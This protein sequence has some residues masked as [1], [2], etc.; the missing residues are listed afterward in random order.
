MKIRHGELKD[1][2]EEKYALYN[3]H[4]FIELDP[5]SIPAR[6][7]K[8]GDIEI[9]G[10]MAAAIAWGQRPV[11]IKNAASLLHAMDDAPHDFI[12]NFSKSDLAPFRKFVHRT[13]NGTDCVFFLKSLQQIY[14]QH[15]SL[16]NLFRKVVDKNSGSYKEAIIGVRKEFFKLTHEP[17]TQ[18]HFADPGKGSAAKR[19]NM[20]LR[21]MIRKDNLGVDFGIWK[22]SPALLTCPL[23]VH[24][25]RVARQLGLLKRK[26]NDW[27][28]AEELTNNLRLFDPSDPVK[29]DF[30]LFGL[31]V[32]NS[33]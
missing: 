17:R 10:F 4:H 1:F 33:L 7:N 23:D 24:S 16:E 6:Y 5:V 27:Q 11:I 19:I 31:G 28:A 21:W 29:F 8:K 9:A 22:L 12:L 25:A 32:S 13:F 20:F 14:R 3:Q 26:Q 18:K 15:N 2:L 30:A